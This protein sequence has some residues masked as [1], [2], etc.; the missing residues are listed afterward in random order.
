MYV[1]RFEFHSG[2]AGLSFTCADFRA[3]LFL[4]LVAGFVLLFGV[5]GFSFGCCELR[6]SF[7]VFRCGLQFRGLEASRVILFVWHRGLKFTAVVVSGL[8]FFI[9]RCEL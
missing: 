6:N 4:F 2:V 9:W 3:S 8:F 1:G 5:A 7:L